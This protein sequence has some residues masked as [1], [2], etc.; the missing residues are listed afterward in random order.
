MGNFILKIT[1][2]YHLRIKKEIPYVVEVLKDQY[3]YIRKQK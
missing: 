1:T 2:K 3:M